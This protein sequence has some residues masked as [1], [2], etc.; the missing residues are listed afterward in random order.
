[1]ETTAP[2]TVL[3]ILP[4]AVLPMSTVAL[5][6]AQ[7]SRRELAEAYREAWLFDADGTL[8]RFDAVRVLGPWGASAPRRL[9]SWLTNGWRVAVD[10]SA[11]VAWDV[12]ALRDRLVAGLHA[13]EAWTDPAAALAA[14]RAARTPRALFDALDLPPP[15]QALDVL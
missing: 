11:P 1:M 8:R 14:L 9:L 12:D 4:G 3:L 6:Q 5:T 15:D 13:A 7:A 10:L 2:R